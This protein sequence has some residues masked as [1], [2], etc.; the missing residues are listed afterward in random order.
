MARCS[1]VAGDLAEAETW[2]AK[3]GKTMRSHSHLNGAIYRHFQCNAA[4][5]RGEWQLALDHARSGMAMALESGVPFLEAHCHIDLARALLGRGDDSEWAEH[6]HAARTIGQAMSSRVVDYLCLEAE[7][8][9]A[10][11]YGKEELGL[12][13]LAQALALSHAMDGAT[14]LMA[15]P[16]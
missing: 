16:Q 6:I 15:G 7:A 10:F 2:L 1:L 8:T 13:R 4:A 3:M 5:Q 12:E 9:A 11:K 14:W